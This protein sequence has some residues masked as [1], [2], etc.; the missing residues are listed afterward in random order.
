MNPY[1]CDQLIFKRM[2]RSVNS[3]RKFSSTN[4]CWGNRSTCKRIYL[5]NILKNSKWI[6]NL[7]VSTETIKTLRQQ[8][9]EIDHDL[10]LD[11][12]ILNT[13]QRHEQQKEKNIYIYRASQS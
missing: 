4:D 7:Y 8:H 13:Q 3:E 12:G 6:N 9:R 2:P 11:N 10:E 1:V 5:K